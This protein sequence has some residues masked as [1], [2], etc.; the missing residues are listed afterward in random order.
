MRQNREENGI[1]DE[2]ELNGHF[3]RIGQRYLQPVDVRARD[4]S[5][6][7]LAEGDRLRASFAVTLLRDRQRPDPEPPVGNG[8]AANGHVVRAGLQGL[9]EEVDVLFEYL[10]PV[11]GNGQQAVQEP[12][13]LYYKGRCFR[14]HHLEDV[15][16][17]LRVDERF[18][19]GT[20]GNSLGVCGGVPNIGTLHEQ[21]EE[22]ARCRPCRNR[23][24]PRRSPQG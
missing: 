19:G 13:S 22:L 15:G 4:T 14:E 6:Q 5:I 20:E 11:V 21:A 7:G 16:F 2:V 12:L 10:A 18:D 23:R 1:G 9:V 3:R 8:F 24:Q 17:T